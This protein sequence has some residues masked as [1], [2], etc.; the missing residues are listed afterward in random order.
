VDFQ[1]TCTCTF[2]GHGELDFTIKT[3]GT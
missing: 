2:I 3:A 1:D